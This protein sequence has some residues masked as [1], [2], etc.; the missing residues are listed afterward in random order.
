MS[1]PLLSNAMI[2]WSSDEKGW[3]FE[4]Q[5]SKQELKLTGWGE[6]ESER[7]KAGKEKEERENEDRILRVKWK[8]CVRNEEIKPTCK[9]KRG[10]E[11]KYRQRKFILSRMKEELR[12]NKV[13]VF[14]V[15]VFG[16]LAAV[17]LNFEWSKDGRRNPSS[18]YYGG[19]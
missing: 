1:S 4:N 16:G 11:R 9:Y 17:W 5:W 6:R 8:I 15:C 3:M 2:K 13:W 12:K 14:F 19:I 10:G 18:I 7:K